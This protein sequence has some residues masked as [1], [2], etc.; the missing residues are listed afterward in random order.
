MLVTGQFIN[1]EIN[2]EQIYI[3]AG[4]VYQIVLETPLAVNKESAKAHF[5]KTKRYLKLYL[6]K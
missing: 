2:S 1:M 3:L 6:E 4:S 5:N